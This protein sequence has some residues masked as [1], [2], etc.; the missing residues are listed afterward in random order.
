VAQL[1]PVYMAQVAPKYMAH[2]HR[3]EWHN[4]VRIAWHSQAEMGGTT[5]N[6]LSII[7][8]L[9]RRGTIGVQKLTIRQMRHYPVG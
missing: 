7:S 8:V 2:Y 3:N 4:L 5:W 9:Q 6:V 1:T